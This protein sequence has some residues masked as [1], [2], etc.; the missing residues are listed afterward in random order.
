MHKLIK[1]QLLDKIIEG[2]VVKVLKTKPKLFRFSK[3]N[4]KHKNR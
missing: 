1:M 3:R 4:F 2:V